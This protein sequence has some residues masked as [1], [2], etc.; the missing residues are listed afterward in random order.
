M[1]Y[2]SIVTEYFNYIPQ[3]VKKTLNEYS[4]PL[5]F[6]RFFI[7]KDYL[8]NKSSTIKF[9]DNR[10]TQR[11]HL[12]CFD[13]Y[14]EDEQYLYP[15]ILTLNGIKSLHDFKPE[16]FKDLLIYKPMV[17]TIQEILSKKEGSI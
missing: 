17:N 11:P 5:T 6:N 2:T 12:F 15:I 16:N 9:D 3:H 14:S 7:Y 8:L 10:W 4:K 13:N 1:Q